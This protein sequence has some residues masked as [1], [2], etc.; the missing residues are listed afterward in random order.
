MKSRFVSSDF[1]KHGAY[2]GPSLRC[3]LKYTD[4]ELMGFTPVDRK[5]KED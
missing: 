5:G 3:H 1:Y 2:H 4:K